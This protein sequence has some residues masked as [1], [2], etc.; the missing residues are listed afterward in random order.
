MRHQNRLLV[1]LDCNTEKLRSCHTAVP[2]GSD[3]ASQQDN[4][5]LSKS[6]LIGGKFHTRVVT[7]N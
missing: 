2:E 4:S 6:N 7:S 5:K 1:S 3:T